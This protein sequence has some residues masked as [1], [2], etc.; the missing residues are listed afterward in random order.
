MDGQRVHADLRRLPAHGRR[1]RRPLRA[2]A[3]VHARRRDLHGRVGGGRARPLRRLADRGSR[4]PGPRRRDRHAADAHHPERG[5]PARPARRRARRVVRHRRARGR[6]GAARR[7]RR[8]GRDLVAVDLLAQRPRRPRAPAAR[9]AAHGVDRPGQG[10]RPPGPRARERRDAR[11]RVGPDPRQRRR[12]DEP[13]HRRRARRRRS[14]AGGIRRLGAP[15]P[16][17]DV[18]DG[19]LP[20]PRLRGR[21]RRLAAHVLRDVRVDLPA[22]AVLP[23][24]AGLLA[25]RVGAP[26]AALDD[27][28]DVRRAD[29]GRAVGSNRRTAAD[30]DGARAPG[31]RPRVDRIRLDGDGRLLVARPAVHALGSRYGALL[32]SR[33]ERRPLGRPARAGGQGVRRQQRDPRGGRR[34]RRRRARLDLRP[35]RV[36]T[37]PR[38]R[39]TTG[40]CLRCGSAPSWSAWERCSR[41]SS[42]ASGGRRRRPSRHQSSSSRRRRRPDALDEGTRSFERPPSVADARGLA[43]GHRRRRGRDRDAPRREPHH[44]GR[45]D[46]Q[47][48]VRARR[49]GA[50]R[51]LPAR[52]A[53]ARS[54]TSS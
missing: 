12:L 14:G 9:D 34:P 40:S 11:A 13:G 6:D 30:G 28:A 18:A 1:A 24:R 49:R 7:R 44:R 52:P 39:S 26:R 37:R 38:W 41:S 48:R 42:R 36:D 22:D 4:R 47:P 35:R 43:R 25:A 3:H 5:R 29:R 16:R 33:R 51:G 32:R 8:R 20:R 53:S 45:P 17:A 54:A 23:D 15:G 50:V 31:D 2:E 21:E 19:L 10:P 27:H 46:E